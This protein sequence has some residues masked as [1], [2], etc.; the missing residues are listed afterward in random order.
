MLD[1]TDPRMSVRHLSGVGICISDEFLETERRHRGMHSDTKNVRGHRCNRIE[2]FD[3]VVKRGALE[4]GLIDVRERSAEQKRVAVRR[5]VGN[6]GGTD[7]TPATSYVFDDDYTKQAFH[8]IRERSADGIEC[9]AGR[10][11][12]HEPDRVSWIALRADN[13]GD[14][15]QRS[16]TNGQ[17]QEFATAK[18]HETSS[19]SLARV[20]DACKLAG[21]VTRVVSTPPSLTSWRKLRAC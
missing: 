15:G 14:S 12:N 4:Q 18:F 7:G 1:R 19:E 13:P 5:G 2:V 3:W 6:R 11:R 8:L 10:K 16:N 20:Q 9:A 17:L 21:L